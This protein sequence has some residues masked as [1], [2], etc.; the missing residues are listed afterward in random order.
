MSPKADATKRHRKVAV[1]GKCVKKNKKN[2]QT[3]VSVEN[4][5]ATVSESEDE[6][7]PAPSRQVSSSTSS[8]GAA[9]GLHP[10]D[11]NAPPQVAPA[12]NAV[13][14]GAPRDVPDVESEVSVTASTQLVVD[15]L[16]SLDPHRAAPESVST[17]APE[18]ASTVSPE[19]TSTAVSRPLHRKQKKGPRLIVNPDLKNVHSSIGNAA[20]VSGVVDMI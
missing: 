17:V 9:V 13:D 20:P 10:G 16:D 3:T 5:T 2:K 14:V 19:S 6:V 15:S 18:S 1:W 8:T 4:A 12:S 7:P 11:S